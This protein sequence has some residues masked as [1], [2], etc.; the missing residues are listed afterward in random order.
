M[1]FNLQDNEG[2]VGFRVDQIAKKAE[3]SIPK[4]PNLIL[5]K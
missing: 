3:L 2:H 1:Y 5:I 4:K